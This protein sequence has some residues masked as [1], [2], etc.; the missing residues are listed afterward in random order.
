[1]GGAQQAGLPHFGGGVRREVDVAGKAHGDQ[2]VP[3]LAF[4]LGDRAD[5]DVTD[6][7]AGILLHRGDVGQLGLYLERTGTAARGARQRQRVQ[8]LPAAS[9]QTGEDKQRNGG[10]G[11]ASPPVPAHAPA[12]GGT[13]KPGS[14]RLGSVATDAGGAPSADVAGG[15]PAS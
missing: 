12:P 1:M 13:I 6:A 3:A 9:R 5:V 4:D 8:A 14:P 10:G 15:A 2:R 7:D 11:G